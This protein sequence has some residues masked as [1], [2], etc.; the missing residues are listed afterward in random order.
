M[1]RSLPEMGPTLRAARALVLLAGFYLLGLAMLG[2]LAVIDWQ[3]GVHL[4]GSAYVK[5]WFV[6]VVVAIPI[7]QGM[8]SVRAPRFEPPNGLRVTEEQEPAL[9]AA[10]R[11]LA[12]EAGTRAPDE[13]YLVPDVNAAVHEEARLLGLLPG[14]RVLMI[15]VPLMTGLTEP[16]LIGVL[17]HEFGHYGNHDT[18]L[19]AIS[20]RAFEQMERTVAALYE[21]SAKKQAKERAKQE[22]KE[23]KRLAKGKKARGV[24]TGHAGLS[25][26]LAAKPFLLYGKLCMRITLGGMRK[27]EYAADLAAAR[28]AGRD[29]TASALREIP[30]LSAAH[31]F[32]MDSYA[33]LGVGAGLL[34]PHGEVYGGL[35]HLLAARADEL[36]GM[37]REVPQE[38]QSPYDS[39]PPIADRVARIEAL[40]DDGRSS[41]GARPSLALLADPARTFAELEHATLTPAALQLRRAESWQQLVSEAMTQYASESAEPLR[42]AVREVHG[43]DGSL[44]SVLRAIEDGALW[45]VAERLPRSEEAAA[46]TGRAAREFARPRLRSMLSTLVAGELLRQGAA[47]WEPSWSEPARLRLPDGHEALLKSALDAAVEDV[48]DTGGIRRLLATTPATATPT[49]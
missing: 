12:D 27:D 16:Q 3:A 40:P 29:A 8:F 37:R 17:A 35:R 25:Y 13:I 49:H 38:E 22:Q 45:Q 15:G 9:W 10:V 33:T 28:I 7:V 20:R 31:G 21:R 34:P 36:D 1:G 26:R 42:A 23:A 4:A 44:D 41:E 18:R 46:A 2:A 24:E 39:H 14:K 30:V 47:H 43:G 5:I 6:S 11:R 32:Y 19:G 48:P